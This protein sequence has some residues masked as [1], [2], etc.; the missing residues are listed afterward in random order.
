MIHLDYVL[1]VLGVGGFVWAFLASWHTLGLGVKAG[2]LSAVAAWIVGSRFTK[3][4]R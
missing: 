3:I 2:M 1:K 4:Y